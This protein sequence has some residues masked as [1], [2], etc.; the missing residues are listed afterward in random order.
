MG[1]WL[2]G[3]MAMLTRKL[4]IHKLGH[5]SA[6]REEIINQH[7]GRFNLRDPASSGQI[8]TVCLWPALPF[9]AF[10]NAYE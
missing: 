5:L 2:D 8:S 4:E 9:A 3:W 7:H 6:C 10:I 1:G